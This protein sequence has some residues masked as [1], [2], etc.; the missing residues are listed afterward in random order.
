MFNSFAS[1]LFFLFISFSAVADSFMVCINP[2][3]F[4][5]W[6]WAPP[7]TS[8][9]HARWGSGNQFIPINEDGTL[10]S[11]NI[12]INKYGHPVLHSALNSQLFDLTKVQFFCDEL[13]SHCQKLG[14]KYSSI[15]VKTPLV[16]FFRF[17]YISFSYYENSKLKSTTCRNMNYNYFPNDGGVIHVF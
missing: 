3:D 1:I 16:P 5:D 4:E 12:S 2:N 7:I 10:L 8:K 6:K 15:H 9:E 11:G 17:A 14:E 13:K